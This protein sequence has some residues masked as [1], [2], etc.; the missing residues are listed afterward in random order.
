MGQVRR[1]RHAET[2]R[3][4]GRWHGDD[5]QGAYVNGRAGA[6]NKE[7]LST[8]LR[9]K[10]PRQHFRIVNVSH[11]SDVHCGSYEASRGKGHPKQQTVGSS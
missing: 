10:N 8:L 1:I 6:M 3:W 5:E 2:S 7:V 11:D 4:Q 9:T